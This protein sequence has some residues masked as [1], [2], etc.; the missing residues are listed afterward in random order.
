MTIV[1]NILWL[2]AVLL[3]QW[4]F[5]QDLPLTVYGN[6]YLYL[7]FF[8]WLPF[9]VTRMGL[10]AIAF[11]VGSIMDAFEQSGGAHT[12]ACLA[13]VTAKPWVESAMIGYRKSDNN[14]GVSHLALVPYLTTSSVLVLLHHTVL[15]TAENYGFYN[16]VLLV[17]RIV[18][19]SLITLVL[20]AITHALFSKK[21]AA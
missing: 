3:V 10:Y 7:W 11:T 18:I 19:S 20:L 5:L 21:Y 17:V 15:F 8:L 1:K 6:P 13:L 12:L 9:G 14:E 16:P 4:G 2:V